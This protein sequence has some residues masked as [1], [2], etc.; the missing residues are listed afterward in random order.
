MEPK[1]S[2]GTLFGLPIFLLIAAV[3]LGFAVLMVWS[4]FSEKREQLGKKAE[5]EERQRYAEEWT[6]KARERVLTARKAEGEDV[7][8]DDDVY[9][10]ELRELYAEDHPG[11]DYRE[12][13]SDLAGYDRSKMPDK[14]E[15]FWPAGVATGV[16]LLVLGLTYWAMYPLEKVYHQ[17]TPMTGVVTSM[18]GGQLES[19]DGGHLYITYV[20]T[21]NG[22]Q[23]LCDTARCG[24]IAV[25]DTATLTCK[26]DWSRVAT[27]PISCNFISVKKA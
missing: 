23:Y 11:G 9:D 7:D 6:K 22:Q 2:N 14:G 13:F 1:W 24:D 12:Y 3:L 18:G 17:W 26:P 25:G 16:A 21:I 8:E 15:H 5:R 27:D 10:W 20:F 19:T 4:Y